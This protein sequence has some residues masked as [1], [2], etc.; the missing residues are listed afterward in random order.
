MARYESLLVSIKKAWAVH[1]PNLSLEQALDG[2]DGTPSPS[3]SY[4]GSLGATRTDETAL[5]ADDPE[6]NNAEEFEFDES[7]EFGDSIDG[8]GFLTL[9]PSKSG[10]TGP[11]SGIAALRV[12][13]SLPS[14]SQIEESDDTLPTNAS[15]NL[16]QPSG[17]EVDTNAFVDDYF[18]VYHPTYPLL[19][20]GSFRA[21]LSGMSL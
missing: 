2:L 18:K 7:Q 12:L 11:Q 21:R 1:V 14:A 13:R 4:H 6:H 17:C 10:Y 9:E 5:V 19:H 20:E 16:Q 15:Q 8:M 3:S